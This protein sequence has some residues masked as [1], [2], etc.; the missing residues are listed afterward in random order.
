MYKTSRQ[1]YA[2]HTHISIS[3]EEA[4]AG[5]EPKMAYPQ[6]YFSIDDFEEAFEDLIVEDED[7]CLCVLL[8]ARDGPTF[9]WKGSNTPKEEKGAKSNSLK[10][11]SAADVEAE[12]DD[13]LNLS[14]S[15]KNNKTKVS[16]FSGYVPYSQLWRAVSKQA[17]GSNVGGF[18]GMSSGS[19]SNEQPEKLVM[20][21]PGGKGH[22]EVAVT[23][24]NRKSV[25]TVKEENTTNA[26]ANA[27]ASSSS[28]PLNAN[29]DDAGAPPDAPVKKGLKS[30][31]SSIQNN[32]SQLASNM[33]KSSGEKANSRTTQHIRCCLM[34]VSLPWESLCHDILKS[35]RM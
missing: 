1:V 13:Q 23:L 8:Y 22:A 18:L 12:A 30:F 4:K 26:N 5:A 34:N 7:H 16:L 21:G 24:L 17:R 31:F 25:H 33:L 14:K 20:R 27:K 28:S 29:E 15:N 2:S 11:S 3:L 9:Q 35:S 19:V 32:A 6:I 10:D